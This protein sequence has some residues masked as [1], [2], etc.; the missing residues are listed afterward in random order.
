M[1][2]VP[3]IKVAY[4]PGDA[5]GDHEVMMLV[6][7]WPDNVMVVLEEFHMPTEPSAEGSKRQ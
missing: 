5:N 1:G 6:E 3:E 2:E 7:W 4:D